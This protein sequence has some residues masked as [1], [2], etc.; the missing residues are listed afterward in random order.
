MTQNQPDPSDA[1]GKPVVIAACVIVFF[2]SMALA[3][4]V[5]SYPRWQGTWLI[6]VGV[7][8]VSVFLLIQARRAYWYRW[9]AAISFGA[10]GLN[11]AVPKIVAWYKGSE[12]EAGILIEG[13]S[14]AGIVMGGLTT[15][16]FGVLAY[17]HDHPQQNRSDRQP[18]SG[19]HPQGAT[20]IINQQ[21]IGTQIIHPPPTAS[22]S[23]P[24]PPP[25]QGLL[26]QLRQPVGDFVGRE[27]LIESLVEKLKRGSVTIS[28]MH[29]LGGIGKTELAVKVASMLYEA[30][31]DA[32]LFLDLKGTDPDP[33]KVLTA[34]DAMAYVIR[35]FDRKAEVGDAID[36]VRSDYQSVLHGKRVLLLM[37]NAGSLAQVELLVPPAGSVM[38]VTSRQRFTL[39]GQGEADRVDLDALTRQE[40]CELLVAICPRIG[41]QAGRIADL[42][43]DLPLAVRVAGATLADRDDLAVDR[44]VQ[45]LEAKRLENLPKV[46]A[47]LG[48][49]YELLAPER[50]LRFTML[51]VFPD[52]FDLPA[53]QAVWGLQ[54]GD[55]DDQDAAEESLGALRRHHLLQWDAIDK[56][57]KLHDLVRE[58]A[59]AHATTDDRTT[60]QRRH[61]QH[62]E[63]VLRAACDLFLQGNESIAPGLALFDRERLNIET[64]FNWAQANLDQ[65]DKAAPLCIQYPDAGVYVLDLR[66]HPQQRITW[67][68]AQATAAKRLGDRDAE[69]K[70]LGNLGNAYAALGEPKRAIGFYEQYLAI[71]REIGDR[72]GEGTALGGLG[73]AYA[74]LGEAKR[75]V[76]FYEQYLAIAR[77]IGY[78]RGEGIALGCLGTAYADLGEAKRAVGFYEQ[79]LAIAREIGD[80]RG[81]GASL[82]NLGN[83]Y[84]DLGEPKRAIG[85][86]EQYLAIAREIGDRRG[87]GNALG[88]LGNAYAA[89]GESKRAIGSYE[90]QLEITRE[91]G[92]RRGEGTALGNLGNAYAALGESKR[93]IGFYEQQLE[94]A[95]EIGDRLGEANASWNLGNALAKQGE[96]DRAVAL[97]RVRVEYLRAIGHPAA[98]KHA[99]A[100]AGLRER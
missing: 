54:L 32:Q 72:R 18:A 77:E 94:I 41:E 11:A 73:N 62:Y 99:A 38:L 65:H 15:I 17:R 52:S 42:C 43:G 16:V 22:P 7:A 40:S 74:D 85:F 25:V 67:L 78:R 83:A 9:M 71:A 75:A 69:C 36:Q 44:Y 53:A 84:A 29:G 93:A 33:A 6:G 26:H 34:V 20:Q 24:S 68:K 82:G 96:V 60:S 31:P 1:N 63:T 92:D 45:K 89:L 79:Y 5:L 66:H 10:T 35:S 90:Q 2:V 28:S 87:E 21:H 50:Q 56:R 70:A 46:D 49:S 8:S 14:T 48:L 86:Y 98:E 91:I 55:A 47:S 64:G 13:L 57:Y 3:W 58:F 61:A 27:G 95:R 30:Y 88:N 81:Q 51:A 23:P 39:P 37:D 80:R 59:H 100:V 19:N 97:M 12:A 4:L 76:G